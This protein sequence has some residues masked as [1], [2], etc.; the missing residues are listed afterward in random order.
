MAIE[1][2]ISW[3][4]LKYWSHRT[5]P[6][7]LIGFDSCLFDNCARGGH[8]NPV[9]K[10]VG[11]WFCKTCK[12][13]LFTLKF[14]RSGAINSSPCRIVARRE[15]HKIPIISLLERYFHGKCQMI[16]ILSSTRLSPLGPAKPDRSILIRILLIRRTATQKASSTRLVEH[17]PERMYSRWH[18]T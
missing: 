8:P 13:A 17:V 4:V 1:G 16:S 15:Q 3:F 5:D 14:A 10:Q 12:H 7:V 9:I 6:G 2:V 18:Q 11:F